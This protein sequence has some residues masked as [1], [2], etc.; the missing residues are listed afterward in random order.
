MACRLLDV[1][2][3]IAQLWDVHLKVKQEGYI[4]VVGSIVRQMD[5]L[6]CHRASPWASSDQITWYMMIYQP[7]MQ[8]P[9]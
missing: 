1:D 6:T 5:I 4:Q 7:W 8:R 2:D 3:F 9:L